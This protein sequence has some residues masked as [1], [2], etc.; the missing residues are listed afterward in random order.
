MPDPVSCTNVPN[1]QF[2]LTLLLSSPMVFVMSNRSSNKKK[3]KKL[4]RINAATICIATTLLGMAAYFVGVPFCDLME[5][6]TVDL[7]FLS[8]GPVDP[9]PEVLLAVIDEKSLEEQGKWTWPRSKFAELVR[10]LSEN[11]ARVIAFDV[12]FLEPDRNSALGT[13]NNF[14]NVIKGLGI[15]N[16]K[17][18]SYL[19]KAKYDADNDLVL[20][21]AIKKSSAKVVLGYF[22]QMSTQGLEHLDENTVKEQIQ[23]SRASRYSLIR[24]TSDQAQRVPLQEAFMPESNIPVI[25][26]ATRY[27]GYFNMFPDRDGS[28]RWVPLV[29]RCQKHL[30]AP[31]SVQALRAY[32]GRAPTVV[33]A[34]YG[35]QEIQIGKL[36]MPTNEF[37]RLMVNYRGNARTFPHLSVTDI[38]NQRIPPETFKDK[39]VLVGATAT[40]IYDMRVTP[41]S[42]VFPGLEIHAN[43]IDNVLHQDFLQAPNWAAIFDLGAI[44]LIGLILGLLLPRI[45]ALSGVSVTIALLVSYIA[46]CQYLFVHLRTWLNIV[47][48]S[49]VLVLTYVSITVYKYL[50]EERQKKFIK[51]AFSTYLAPSVVGQLIKSPEKLVL[52]G[53][54]RVITAYFSDVQGFTSIS[55]KLTPE[56]LVE[57]LNEFLTEMTDI[58]LGYEGTLDKFE[59]DAIIAFFG[60]PNTLED[61]AARACKASLDMQKRLVGLRAKCK[62]ENRPELKMRIGLSSGSAVV[63]NMGSKN[64]MDYTM[65]GDTVNTASRL[66]GVNKVYGSYMMISQSTYAAAKDQIFARELDAINVV[67]KGAPV[68]VYQLLGYP[69][70]I[71]DKQRSVVDKYVEGLHAYRKH[72]WNKAISYFSAALSIDPHDSPSQT[73]L[74]RCKD[75]KLTPPGEDWDGSFTMTAR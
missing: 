36:P 39:I 63:G 73:M 40:G 61:H 27:S 13:V 48:P 56:Q 22:F 30:Y 65:M 37:G 9:G 41:F 7:R 19:K 24:Y 5:L 72:N 32:T 71:D 4:L 1:L 11:G 16:E 33:I 2:S 59:G 49:T 38:L 57:L 21:E 25:A 35:V 28:V 14:E 51:D 62:A 8:R 18:D 26:R 47:Y 12:G 46:V 6:K 68:V 58:I 75:Y 43:I 15:K 52:G 31:L 3:L 60:A 17:L 44:V 74:E 69:E 53:E 23:N 55:E 54:E 45:R 67:G 34:D 10:T 66:E 42:S 64:R 29:I 20:A 70:E 50:A